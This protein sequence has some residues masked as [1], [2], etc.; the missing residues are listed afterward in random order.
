MASSRSSIRLGVMAS[1][2]GSNLQAIIDRVE[3]G[4]LLAEIAVVVGNRAE[5]KAI[6]RAR[7]HGAPVAVFERADYPSRF[8]RDRAMAA[9]LQEYEVDLVVMAGYDQLVSDEFLR[10][11]EGRIINIHPSLL[12]AFAGGLHAQLD[13]WEYGVKLAGCTVHFVTVGPAD[14][15]QIIL[16]KA[17]PVLDDDTPETLADRILVEEH[18]LLPEGIRLFAEGRLEIRGR[19]VHIV[20]AKAVHNE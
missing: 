19:R 3:R 15:G 7:K 5:A 1:G 18:K 6:S 10:T 4:E 2:R 14:G 8:A 13:A 16:Q 20:P 11:F 17:V 12:P 9:C